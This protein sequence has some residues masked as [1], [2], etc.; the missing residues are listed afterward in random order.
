MADRTY[1]Y[2]WDGLDGDFITSRVNPA[3]PPTFSSPSL[4]PMVPVT[5]EETSVKDLDDAMAELG[6]VRV[7]D[8]GAVPGPS[9]I[10]DYGILPAEPTLLA[11]SAGDRY[12]NSANGTFYQ[13]NGTRWVAVSFTTEEAAANIFAQVGSKFRVNKLPLFGSFAEWYGQSGIGSEDVFYGRV[14]LPADTYVGMECLVTIGAN[15]VRTVDMGVYADDGAA[16]P[17]PTGPKLAS[18][19][20]LAPDVN[21]AFFVQPFTADLVVPASGFYWL[22]IVASSANLSFASTDKTYNQAWAGTLFR[23]QRNIGSSTL[24]ASVGAL[25]AAADSAIPY[26]AAEREA[27]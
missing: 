23:E 4:V 1:L 6:F 10:T 3:T 14:W 13:Y 18:T 25:D 27:P 8:L 5:V 15:E 16:D 11:P 9:N 22:A 7:A 26:L 21:D 19:G 2:R 17:A 12:F 24:P 20:P